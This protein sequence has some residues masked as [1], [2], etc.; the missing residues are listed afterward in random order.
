M[1]PNFLEHSIQPDPIFTD[2]AQRTM[3]TTIH[4]EVLWAQRSSDGDEAKVR[5]QPLSL[6]C[7]AIEL[8]SL[9]ALVSLSN[10]NVLLVTVNLPNIQE[11][12]LKYELTPTSIS[13]KAT[14]GQ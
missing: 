9:Y 3:A 5:A 4:P 12:T 13:F 1:F 11:S 8:Y 10:Q 2:Y 6:E 7:V 14:V